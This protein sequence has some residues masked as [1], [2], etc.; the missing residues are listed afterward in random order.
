[1]A[2]GVS[3]KISTRRQQKTKNLLLAR[4]V[5]HFVKLIYFAKYI[6][7]FLMPN[8]ETSPLLSLYPPASYAMKKAAMS[9]LVTPP[10]RL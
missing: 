5:W 6:L 1:V 2:N 9:S 7:F 8:H 10:T 4:E 3:R